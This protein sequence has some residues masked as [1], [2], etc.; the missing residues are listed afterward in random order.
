MADLLPVH[1][2]Y[3]GTT[4]KN[5]F[6]TSDVYGETGGIG[7]KVKIKKI[8]EATLL[9]TETIVPVKELLRNGELFRIGIRY[10]NAAN[11]RK[12]ARIL[13]AGSAI[14]PIFGDVPSEK[15][16]GVAY[17]IG[18]GEAK[19]NITSIGMIRRATTY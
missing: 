1:G 17:K 14:S 19:G 16:E 12:S 8:P 2:I 10:K 5:Y 7:A 15:L 6:R 18:A 9:G 4:V 11:K 13:V 3:N